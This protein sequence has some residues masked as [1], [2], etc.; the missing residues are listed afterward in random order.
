MRAAKG[1]SGFRHVTS[2][3]VET[4]PNSQSVRL[5]SLLDVHTE[6]REVVPRLSERERPSRPVSDVSLP[7]DVYNARSGIGRGTMARRD[8][9]DT[10][11]V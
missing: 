9:F 3:K 4:C 7:H 1:L 11:L 10:C 8:K 6:L 2:S 5:S